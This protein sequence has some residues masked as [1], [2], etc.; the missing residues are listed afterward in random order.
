MKSLVFVLANA[1][2]IS[3]IFAGWSRAQMPTWIPVLMLF[4]ANIWLTGARPS[5]YVRCGNDPQKPVRILWY[6]WCAF[7]ALYL[8]R[9]FVENLEV[10]KEGPWAQPWLVAV[11]ISWK[12]VV[13]ILSLANTMV[14]NRRQNYRERCAT[15]LVALGAYA[16]GNLLWAEFKPVQG[17]DEFG[18][19]RLE[20]KEFR[21]VPPLARSNAFFAY[22][23]ATA[24]AA[25][26][27]WGVSRLLRRDIRPRNLLISA[28]VAV[29]SVVSAWGAYRAE[30]RSNA[31]GVVAAVAVAVVPFLRLR[32][33]IVAFLLTVTIVFPLLFFGPM[34]Y[35]VLEFLSPEKIASASGA[36][37]QEDATLTYRTFL[38][39]YAATRLQ[40]PEVFLIGEGPADRDAQPGYGIF[41]EGYRMNFHSASIEFLMA[42]GVPLGLVGYWCLAR[43]LQLA[44]RVAG[45]ARA[46]AQQVEMMEPWIFYCAA[47]FVISIVD[48]G[49]ATAEGFAMI[50][51]PG[52]GLL[53]IENPLAVSVP[54]VRVAPIATPRPSAAT[55][56]SLDAGPAPG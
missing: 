33:A 30:F 29:A 52:F 41:Y 1:A 42:N 45:R 20:G 47:A 39:E 43:M 14:W 10:M 2:C 15:L 26:F 31:V 53:M 56:P 46:P 34:G 13:F 51:L 49:V 22:T 25:G 54:R 27:A 17:D 28:C 18:E 44:F 37:G 4:A 5:D 16:F 55:A 9:Q 24:F 21:W 7:I 48:P 3:G 12:N 38:W 6:V 36:R 35:I 11:D 8:M 40:D 50:M 32:A 19:S 23:C